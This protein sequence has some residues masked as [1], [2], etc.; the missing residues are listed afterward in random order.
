MKHAPATVA[1][2]KAPQL[3]IE[4]FF[5][6]TLTFSTGIP[7]FIVSIQSSGVE[8]SLE[9]GGSAI[10]VGTEEFTIKIEH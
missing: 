6:N 7:A 9:Y 1:A 4:A 2:V 10:V 3:Q 5:C 8:I